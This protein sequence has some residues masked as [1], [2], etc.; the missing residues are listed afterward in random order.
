MRT[1]L[2]AACLS[3]VLA[4][5]SSDSSNTSNPS[6][7][8]TSFVTA[9]CDRL[10]A[11]QPTAAAAAYGTAANCA[12]TLGTEANCSTASCASGKSFN[13]GQAQTCLNDY[14]NQTCAAVEGATVPTSCNTV[15]Q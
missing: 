6:Q 5:C 13:S 1:V 12:T 8:C 7:A 4:G 2:V 14:K 11:C 15:C 9:A 3:V 10:F